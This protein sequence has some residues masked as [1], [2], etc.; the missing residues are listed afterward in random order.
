MPDSRIWKD[1]EVSKKSL[2]QIAKDYEI[3]WSEIEK[4]GTREPKGTQI[5]EVKQR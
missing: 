4:L 2:K 3:D 1:L 5:R